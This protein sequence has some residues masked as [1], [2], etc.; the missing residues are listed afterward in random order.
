MDADLDADLFG[1]QL[2][3]SENDTEPAEGSRPKRDE[4]DTPADRTAQSEAEFQ[5]VR[6]EYRV[7]VENGE[8]WKTV[9]LPLG[10]GKVPKPEA[11]ALLH[12]VEELY[13]FRRYAEGARFVNQVLGRD[14]SEGDGG[15]SVLDHDTRELLRYYER[16]CNEKAALK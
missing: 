1:I 14:I 13:F 2:S 5:A 15:E 16:K 4:S 7:K 9:R 10:P 12:A 6:Q 8:I 11:Q 3:D